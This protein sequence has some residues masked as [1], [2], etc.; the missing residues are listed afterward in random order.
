LAQKEATC[1][2]GSFFCFFDGAVSVAIVA[3]VV[4]LSGS[5]G[6]EGLLLVCGSSPVQS[7]VKGATHYLIT[8][9]LDHPISLFGHHPQHQNISTTSQFFINFLSNG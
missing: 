4:E 7:V 2:C 9:S 8:P 6:E 3:L 5:A 1:S